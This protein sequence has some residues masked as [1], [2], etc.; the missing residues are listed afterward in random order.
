MN[1][2]KTATISQMQTIFGITI[3]IFALIVLS[4][5]AFVLFG[6][7]TAR[8]RTAL[9]QP[10][11]TIEVD[12]RS[13][14]YRFYSP[15]PDE[16]LPLVVMLHGYNY[17]SGRASEI[18]SGWSNL[19][20]ETGEFAVVYPEGIA[21]SWNGGFCCGYA[22]ARNIN[23]VRFIKQLVDRLESDHKLSGQ[24]HIVGFSNGSFLAQ[25]LLAEQPDLFASGAAVMTGIGEKDGDQLDLSG[26]TAPLMI[27]TGAEDG[28]TNH[29][30]SRRGFRFSSVETTLETWS[31][32]LNVTQSD[33]SETDNYSQ[34]TYQTDGN[35]TK[36]IY[37]EYPTGH[38]WPMWRL[39]MF[40]DEYSPFTEDIWRT[41][42]LLTQER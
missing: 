15:N 16:K 20:K 7:L 27:V 41:L 6:R 4:F 13:R 23:D 11:Q 1:I 32:Q 12:G 35:Q 30:I 25:R 37:R 17:D 39:W 40:N 34:L 31:S 2:P 36:L 9:V 14:K 5:L 10:H 29:D 21:R 3:S 38:R 22:Y 42:Q 8:D 24:R 33:D 28:Y 18:Y 26:A 19:A